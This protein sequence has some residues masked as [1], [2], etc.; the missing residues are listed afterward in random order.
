[1]CVSLKKNRSFKAGTKLGEKSN[2]GI[3]LGEKWLRDVEGFFGWLGASTKTC[4][5]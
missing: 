4:E 1:M 2:L 3:F 5:I